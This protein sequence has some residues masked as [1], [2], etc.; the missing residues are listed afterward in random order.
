VK[1]I[2]ENLHRGGGLRGYND[3][4]IK[5][6]A[7][8]ERRGD[9]GPVSA[10]LGGEGS[11]AAFLFTFSDRGPGFSAAAGAVYYGRLFALSSGSKTMAITTEATYENGV[12]RPAQPLPL[13]EHDK[14][15]ITIEL[16]PSRARQTAGLMGWTGGAE[17]AERF[18]TDPDLD[19]PPPPEAP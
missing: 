5:P 17:L 10:W 16:R 3:D 14:V 1:A 6:G 4:I 7:Q 8:T 12:L 19:F 15:R 18:A 9:A 13:K 2:A 11:P